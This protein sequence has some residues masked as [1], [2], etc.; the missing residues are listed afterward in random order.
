MLAR[1][2]G[3]TACAIPRRPQLIALLARDDKCAT[4][5]PP[6]DAS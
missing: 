4:L 6:N 3:T 1:H 5:V 2:V